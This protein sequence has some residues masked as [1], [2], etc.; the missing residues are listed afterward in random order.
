MK[1]FALYMGIATGLVASCS[2]QEEG[3]KTPQQ[4]G[5]FYYAYFEQ[6][7]E[8]GTKVYAN[9]DLITEL[10]AY[11]KSLIYEYVTGKKEVL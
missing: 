5:V 10:E 9:E 11:K 3:F 2:V 1:R 6:P 8:E 4:E 7:A